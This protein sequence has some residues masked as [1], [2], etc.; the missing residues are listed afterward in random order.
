MSFCSVSLCCMKL[1]LSAMTFMVIV[2]LLCVI[3]LHVM[4]P[5]N[6]IHDSQPK[7]SH[8]SVFKLE[9]ITKI[10]NNILKSLIM[11]NNTKCNYTEHLS[12]KCLYAGWNWCWLPYIYTGDI[13]GN[14]HSA[15]CLSVAHHSVI[16]YCTR[17]PPLKFL[18][19]YF[20]IGKKLQKSLI[21]FWKVD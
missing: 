12:A 8:K 13:Y 7:N 18:Q 3:L 11:L 19:I 10:Y 1:M 4:A 21:T 2:I 20:Q 9:K 6:I 16:Q 14:C 15:L 5:L 17:Q